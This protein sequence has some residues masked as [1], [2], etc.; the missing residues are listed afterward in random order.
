MNKLHKE[1]YLEGYLNTIYYGHGAYG[2]EAASRL[3]LASGPKIS[4]RRRLQ[5]LPAFQRVLQ[6]IRPLSMKKAKER[7]EMILTMMEKQNKLTEMQ[8]AALKNA[9]P[10]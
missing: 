7:Q 3:Y 4:I 8:A 10:L 9:A 1:R 5:C 2:I 6:F